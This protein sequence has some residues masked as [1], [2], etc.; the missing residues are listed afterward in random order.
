MSEIW[1]RDKQTEHWT[2]AAV[3][4][5]TDGGKYFLFSADLQ[6]YNNNIIYTVLSILC[7]LKTT[8]TWK[9]R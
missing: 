7:F 8:L 4:R 6:V 1:V 5:S 2:I 3:D 9:T